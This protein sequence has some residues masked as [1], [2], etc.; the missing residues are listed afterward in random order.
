MGAS[1][2]VQTT[3]LIQILKNIQPDVV[4]ALRPVE[5]ITAT[6]L[7]RAGGATAG[8][9][10][11]RHYLS[12]GFTMFAVVAL[13]LAAVG[14]Y[15]VVAYSVLRRTHEIGVRMALGAERRRVTWMIVEQG[16][17]VSLIGVIGGLFLS[18]VATKVVGGFI[19]DV[20]MDYPLAIAG[21]ILFVSLVSLVASAIPGYRAGRLN[22]V[23]ALRAD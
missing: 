3:A 11:P 2:P 9:R 12:I 7:A 14:T 17:K 19:Q 23:D 16:L 8:N 22:P 4:A 21:V 10:N 13:I 5:G 6:T 18:F 15:G 20:N 1:V